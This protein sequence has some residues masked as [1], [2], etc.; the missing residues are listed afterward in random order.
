LIELERAFP[1]EFRKRRT[2]YVGHHQEIGFVVPTDF[3]YRADVGV[4]DTR[5][6]LGFALKSAA[7]I[8]VRDELGQDALQSHDPAK[9]QIARFVYDAYGA[10]AELGDDLVVSQSPPNHRCGEPPF[11]LALQR[12]I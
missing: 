1:K 3:V 12:A 4:L 5:R 10:S 8:G 6:R 9:T 11:R 2:V 7:N